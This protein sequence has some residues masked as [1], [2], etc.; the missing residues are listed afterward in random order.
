M[1][2]RPFTELDFA[3]LQALDLEQL[4]LEY[5]HFDSLEEKEKQ[6][7][8]RT[9]LPALK[10]YERSEHSFVAEQDDVLQGAIFAQSVWQGDRPTVLVSRVWVRGDDLEIARGLLRACAKSTYDAAVYE[11]HAA[12]PQKWLELGTLEEFK[13]EGLYGVRL[14][15]GRSSTGPGVSL[16]E[17]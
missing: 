14:M 13:A 3:A 12:F 6:G 17:F 10:F 11:I 8:I 1:M 16:L 2:Y 5:P 9:S 7:R 4:N 15:G